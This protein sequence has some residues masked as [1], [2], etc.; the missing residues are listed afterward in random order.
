M[1]WEDLYR[2]ATGL[3]KASLYINVVA[4]VGL[5]WTMFVTVAAIRRLDE[6]SDSLPD[7]EGGLGS[8]M[9]AFSPRPD[10]LDY[11]TTVSGSAV[12]YAIVTALLFSTGYIVKA[13]GLVAEVAVLDLD[14][15]LES[16]PEGDSAAD[17]SEGA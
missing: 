6:L 13:L 15:G 7:D 2:R 4:T 17:S 16:D 5:V 3:S 8:F 1:P 10:F 9:G 14:L 12:T 11:A